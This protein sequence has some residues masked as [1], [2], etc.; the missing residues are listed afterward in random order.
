MGA[1]INMLNKLVYLRRLLEVEGNK[2]LAWNIISSLFHKR[3]KPTKKKYDTI[4]NKSTE[5]CLSQKEIE[6]GESEIKEYLPGF[7]Y[8]EI[9]ENT[10][11]KEIMKQKYINSLSNYEKL[12]IY[13][14]MY[15]DKRDSSVIRKFVNETFHIENDSIFQLNPNRY[16]TVPQYVIDECDKVVLEEQ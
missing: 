4:N 13:R 6:K 5:E 1:N 16:D 12:H 8:N 10:Q 3:D 14:I 9:Y 15:N 7:D 11:D 2:N